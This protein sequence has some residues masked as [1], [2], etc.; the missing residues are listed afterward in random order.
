M[1]QKE[2][3]W[4]KNVKRPCIGTPLDMKCEIC[5]FNKSRYAETL[6]IYPTAVVTLQE[7]S[8]RIGLNSKS[9]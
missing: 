5:W 1:A 9:I 7:E 3:E 2:C 6:V 8:E 4:L